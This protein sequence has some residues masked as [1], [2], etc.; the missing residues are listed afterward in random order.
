MDWTE[1]VDALGDRDRAGA[2]G[3]FGTD[4][5]DATLCGVYGWWAD[6][7][8][9]RVV[10][11]TLDT[12][13]PSLLYVG[14]AGGGRSK[15]TFAGRVLRNHLGG[16]DRTST[17]R[18]SLTA[19]LMAD[20]EFAA[21]HTDPRSPETLRAVSDWMRAHLSIAVVAVGEPEHVEAAELAAI[22]RYDPPLNLR[23]VALTPARVRLRQLR[24]ALRAQVQRAL[25]TRA[26]SA[27]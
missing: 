4:T 27:P 17:L 10:E 13:V 24:V 1:L 23:D 22:R 2:A 20:P 21:A 18:Q 12:K 26:D 3:A 15:Q 14:K 9:R 7:P 16:S 8:A 11:E 19:I 25:A 6:D 5:V